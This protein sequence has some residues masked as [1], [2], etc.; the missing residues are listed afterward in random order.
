MIL[1]LFFYLFIWDGYIGGIVVIIYWKLVW[2]FKNDLISCVS[3]SN[4]KILGFVN[5]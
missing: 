3:G 5:I 2:Y 1:G 4:I